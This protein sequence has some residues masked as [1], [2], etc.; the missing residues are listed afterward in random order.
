MPEN[1]TTRHERPTSN[2]KNIMSTHP[3]RISAEPLSWIGFILAVFCLKGALLR[4]D[5]LPQFF[6][7]DSY[8]YLATAIFQWIPPDRSFVYGLVVR[9]FG[10]TTRSLETILLFQTFLGAVT[11]VLTAGLLTRYF[12]VRRWIAF[13]AGLLCAV[14]PLQLLYERYLLTETMSLCVFAVYLLLV[15]RYLETPRLTGLLLQQGVGLLLIS[16]RI[17][18]LPILLFNTAALPLLA[19]PLPGLRRLLHPAHAAPTS[20]N[21]TRPI[22]LRAGLHLAVSL[23]LFASIQSSYKHLNA[24]LLKAPHPAYQYENGFFLL[25]DVAPVIQPGDFPDPQRAA[26]FMSNLPQPLTDRSQRTAHRWWGDGLVQRLR[27]A[28]PDPFEANQVAA[29]AASPAIRR[30]PLGVALLGGHS[31]TDYWKRDILDACMKADMGSRNSYSEALLRNT[32]RYFNLLLEQRTD[33]ITPTQAWF[34]A[35]RWWYPLLLL[36][37]VPALGALLLCPAPVRKYTLCFV[38]C[39]CALVLVAVFLI[40]RPTIRYLHAAGWL[41]LLFTALTAEWLAARRASRNNTPPE[42]RIPRSETPS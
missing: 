30:D 36:T 34:L 39:A 27:A 25:A 17:S 11:A 41:F 31:F 26:A 12:G 10:I 16:L 14:E 18:F 6:M 38:V 4:L 32:W 2:R 8:S 29:A 20:A 21:P 19:H 5:S 22:L 9:G 7:G 35:A 42:K 23:L 15:C 13:S 40:E 3:P 37:P 33:Q 1:K 24:H 28:Y